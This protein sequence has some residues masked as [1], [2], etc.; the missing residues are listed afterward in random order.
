M[1]KSLRVNNGFIHK[2]KYMGKS[3]SY[4]ISNKNYWCNG[5]DPDPYREGE[6]Y[7]HLLDENSH[8]VWIS[9]KHC[10]TLK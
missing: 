9:E 4:L 10:K 5:F 2:V 1:E 6:G 3:N 8:G 7:Y